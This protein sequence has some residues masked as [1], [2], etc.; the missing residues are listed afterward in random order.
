MVKNKHIKDEYDERGGWEMIR[1][2]LGQYAEYNKQWDVRRNHQ[3]F[4]T[5]ATK[6]DVDY[7]KVMASPVIYRKLCRLKRQIKKWTE[8]V[9]IA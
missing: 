6:D 9:W 3:F 5:K 2:K 8:G 4:G 1:I 7:D